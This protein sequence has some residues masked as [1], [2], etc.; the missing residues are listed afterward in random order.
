MIRTL[1]SASNGEEPHMYKQSFGTKE[2][3]SFN[4]EAEYYELL[5]YLSKNDG[6]TKIVW[7]YNDDQGAWGQEGR[8][9]FFVS[10]PTNLRANLVHTAG[11]GNI[12]SRV[13][14]N[15]FVNAII[16]Y[17]NFVLGDHQD[18]TLIRTTVPSRYLD[19]FDSGTRL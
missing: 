12:I 9:V 5:G 1:K 16:K 8:I 7:E 3:I 10:Q 6:T 2:Q 17:H 19:E 18:I 14:C 4:S 13:N 11:S 15:E